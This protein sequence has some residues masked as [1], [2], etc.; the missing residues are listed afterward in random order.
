MRGLLNLMLGLRMDVGAPTAAATGWDG[1]LYRAWTE[2]AHMAVVIRTA[3][4]SVE[5][6][7]EFAYAMG[8]WIDAG[9]QAARVLPVQGPDVRIL[10]ASDAPT[11]ASLGAAAG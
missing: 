3:W 11:L 4:D 7:Q 8:D 9:Q 1:G 2:G 10:F 5:D 6:A